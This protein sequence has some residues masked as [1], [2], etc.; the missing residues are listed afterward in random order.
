MTSQYTCQDVYRMIHVKLHVLSLSIIISIHAKH[1]HIT[2][3]LASIH[4]D[5]HKTNYHYTI[6]HK[7]EYVA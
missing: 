7:D 4:I 1:I 2:V 3:T 6:V 5:T